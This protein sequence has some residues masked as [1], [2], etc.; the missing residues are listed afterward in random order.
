M[1]AAP[2]SSPRQRETSPRRPNPA[3]V[4]G[5]LPRL[6]P[7]VVWPRQCRQRATSKL[8]SSHRHRPRSTIIWQPTTPSSPSS[9]L[10]ARSLSHEDVVGEEALCAPSPVRRSAVGGELPGAP[11]EET[12]SPSVSPR[13]LPI[14]KPARATLALALTPPSAVA[15]SSTRAIADPSPGAPSLCCRPRSPSPPPCYPLIRLREDL[16]RSLSEGHRLS[17]YGDLVRGFDQGGRRL[18]G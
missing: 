18:G 2:K 1:F 13:P 14:V 3:M 17:N 8:S 4:E 12:R 16:R 6:L 11:H 9:P 10:A 5:F 7:F 15:P